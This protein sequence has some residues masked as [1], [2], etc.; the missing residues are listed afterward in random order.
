MEV[1]V[2]A[3]LLFL[4]NAGMDGLCLLL[5]GRLLHRRI[6]AWRVAVGAVLGGVYAVAALLLP[7]MGQAPSLLC[8]LAVCIIMCATVFGAR[9]RGWLKGILAAA[10]AYFALSMALG[11]VMTA[12]YHL[13]N[14]AGVASL[15][16]GLSEG[17]GDGL[18]S[19]LFLALVLIGGGVSLW[20]GRLLRRSRAVRICTV[21][22]E[23]DGRTAA[24]RGM[25]DSGNLLRDP[26]SGRVVICADGKALRGILSPSLAAVMKGASPDA[27][28]LSPADARR[29]RVIPA[30]TATGEGLLYGFVPD[31][32]T[33]TDEGSNHVREI[34]AVLAVTAIPTEG[35]EA[36]IPSALV[37]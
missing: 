19:W 5:T 30:G 33:L 15:L 8:D 35:V 6:K 26:M 21:A 14:R 20:G 23:L 37:I 10:G 28:R 13:L 16:A 31:H 9:R 7:D 25:V 2:Y 18:G 22:V 17:G 29:V 32:I 36:L 11:G 1:A 3:D 24:L 4:I 12:L 34:D 27:V